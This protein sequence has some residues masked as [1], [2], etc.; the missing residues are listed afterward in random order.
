MQVEGVEDRGV[1]EGRAG[2][3]EAVEGRRALL[4]MLPVRLV[5]R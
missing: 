5:G 1:A 2:A 4:G 3:R